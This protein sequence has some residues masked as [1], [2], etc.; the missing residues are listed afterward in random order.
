MKRLNASDI[1]IQNP[2][3]GVYFNVP[4]SVYFEIE[5]INNSLLKTLKSESPAHYK[6]KKETGQFKFTKSMD[7]GSIC[8]VL[9]LQPERLDEHVKIIPEMSK[10]SKD[11]QFALED[12]FPDAATDYSYKWAENR[13]IIEEAYPDMILTE[14]STLDEAQRMNE[15][16]WEY[17]KYHGGGRLAQVMDGAD[18]EVVMIWED[19]A[20]GI[21]LKC[22]F[23][24]L[25]LEYGIGADYK[26]SRDIHPQKFK[27]QVSDYGYHRALEFYDDG[28]RANGIELVN[29]SLIVQ[30][31]SAPYIHYWAELEGEERQ[32]AAAEIRTYLTQLAACR[33]DDSWPGYRD[34]M[35]RNIL[36]IRLKYDDYHNDDLF[37]ELSDDLPFSEEESEPKNGDKS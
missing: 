27:Y 26:T 30:E 6:Y 10:N 25:N 23:D 14:R 35:N 2:E 4:D 21:L 3:P 15:R 11:F 18:T 7:L 29:N 16:L 32:I 17:D 24:I 28:A 22:K 1:N 33:R 20:T 9:L 36:P 34:T 12:M 31:T 5:A 13:A 8:H 37:F 19:E